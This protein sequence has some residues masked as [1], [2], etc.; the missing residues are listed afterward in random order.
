[1]QFVINSLLVVQSGGN[2]PYCPI[3]QVIALISFSELSV[4]SVQCYSVFINYFVVLC[5]EEVQCL[6]SHADIFKGE[7]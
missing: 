2:L 7:M 3:E 1:M 6:Q 5:Y 4:G